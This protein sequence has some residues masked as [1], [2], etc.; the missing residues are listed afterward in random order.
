MRATSP[1]C[2]VPGRFLIVLL[3]AVLRV[4]FVARLFDVVLRLPWA[5]MAS[6]EHSVTPDC[7]HEV[8]VSLKSREGQ[9]GVRES[10]FLCFHS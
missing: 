5:C 2:V 9:V 4:S 3:V 8:T 6:M 1:L 7:L 10:T